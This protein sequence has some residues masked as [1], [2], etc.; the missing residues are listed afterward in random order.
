ME[1]EWKKKTQT[2]LDTTPCIVI[3]IIINQP[4]SPVLELCIGSS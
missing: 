2:S 3:I 1:E 4:Q